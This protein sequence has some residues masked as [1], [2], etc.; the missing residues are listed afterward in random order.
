LRSE[1]VDVGRL[2]SLFDHEAAIAVTSA[3]RPGLLVLVRAPDPARARLL[4]AGVE[5]SLASLFPTPASGP[6]TT[7]VFADHQIAGVDVHSLQLAPGLQL[8]YAVL[9]HLIALST[10]TQAIV[11]VIRRGRSLAEDRG[12]RAALGDTGALAARD[13]SLVFADLTQLVRLGRQFGLV[14]ATGSG[15]LGSDLARIRFAGARTAGGRDEST[16]E[17]LLSIP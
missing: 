2:E 6:G 3:G 5:P 14:R 13:T 9:D 12:F 10:S 17:L 4:L 16:A 7:P 1:G 8:D 11:S 15:L